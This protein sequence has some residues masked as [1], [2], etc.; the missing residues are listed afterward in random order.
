MSFTSRGTSELLVGGLQDTMYTV[1]AERGE[2]I[3]EV[4]RACCPSGL[5]SAAAQDLTFLVCRGGPLYA[6]EAG[7]LYLCS[8]VHGQ[9]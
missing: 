4:G 6:D 2:I 9:R 7:S 5:P 8:Y 3:S 1:N